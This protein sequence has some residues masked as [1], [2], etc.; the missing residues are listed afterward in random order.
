MDK[1]ALYLFSCDDKSTNK[2][3]TYLQLFELLP[4]FS[5]SNKYS[6]VQ[7]APMN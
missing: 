7:A 4:W 2:S 6:L 1:S 5:Y 3:N